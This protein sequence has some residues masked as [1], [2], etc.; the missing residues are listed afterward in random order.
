[1]DLINSHFRSMS[2]DAHD[3]LARLGA[4]YSD[5]NSKVNLIS[6]KDMEHFYER[7]VLHSL[8][9]LK[10]HDFAAG[11]SI[12]DVGTGGGFPGIPMAIMLPEVQFTL[13]DS[14]QK[15]IKVVRD[16][17]E[18]LGLNN[19]TVKAERMEN[20]SGKY[21]YLI[22]RAV[23]SLPQV[24]DWSKHL[25]NWKKGVEGGILYIKGGNFY[26]ELDEISCHHKMHYLREVFDGEFFETK[27]VVHLFK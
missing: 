20:L 21:D 22:G 9:I 5:W 15:K 7:H 2:Q 13:V 1:M 18:Q 17:S 11:S 25:I 14:I 3:R 4:I 16:V 27:K 8:S 19:V 24:Y 10:V 12:I 23:K 26:E 6:R